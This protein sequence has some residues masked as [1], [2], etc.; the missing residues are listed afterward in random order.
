MRVF[1]LVCY[2]KVKMKEK[3]D[4]IMKQNSISTVDLLKLDT[5]LIDDW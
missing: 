2:S 5:Y 3:I 1:L 4:E